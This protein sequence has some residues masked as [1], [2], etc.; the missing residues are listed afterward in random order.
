MRDKKLSDELIKYGYVFSKSKMIVTYIIMVLMSVVV[1][2]FFRLN[3][4]FIIGLCIAVILMLPLYIKNYNYNRYQQERFSDVNIYMEQFMYSFMKNGK[5]LS[6]LTD[7]S[8][9]FS[10]G[11][12][13]DVI[14]RAINHIKDT[15][16]ESDVESSAL[17]IV[18]KEYNYE[19]LKTMHGFALSVEANGGEY[20]SC[21]QLILEFRRMW[22]DR[23]YEQMKIRKHQKTVVLMS[24]MTS[25]LLCLILYYMTKKMD[26]DI[27]TQMLSQAVT[28]IVLILDVLIYYFANRKLT[29]DVLEDDRK[30]DDIMLAKYKR[31]LRYKEKPSSHPIALRI[32][33]R[34]LTRE[35]EKEFPRWLLSVSLLLQSENV[36]VA[37]FKSLSDAPLLLKDEI[38]QLI[39]A[40]KEDPTGMMPYNN[41]LK[42]F[43]LPEI[44][45]AMKMLFSL[46]EGTGA[47]AS[48]QI[49]DIIRRNQQMMDKAEKLHMEDTASGMYALFLAP[50]IT[51]GLKLMVDMVLLLVCY[52]GKMF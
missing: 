21:M 31:F 33:K 28:F 40:L 8:Q 32:T 27:S 30:S 46:S 26:V 12:M 42:D 1:G 48:D 6:T 7:V 5:I 15:Y 17:K 4:G 11:K 14:T 37:I 35:I 13:S 34:Q 23:V 45:S 39:L 44:R 49:E 43:N 50:Q 52:L 18:E 10:S 47:N 38:K 36:Q 19:G 22:A 51:G 29:V 25:L 9:L 20:I 3:T 24:I 2:L 41:F 16:E